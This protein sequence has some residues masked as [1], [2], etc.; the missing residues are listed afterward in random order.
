[1]AFLSKW[2]G[3]NNV[4]D[5]Q[6]THPVKYSYDT[7]VAL[8]AVHPSRKFPTTINQNTQVDNRLVFGVL[9]AIVFGISIWLL[10]FHPESPTNWMVYPL[11]A[12][13]VC[14]GLVQIALHS[15][16]KRLS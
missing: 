7:N 8:S 15:R 16:G 3:K 5:G 13:A 10:A 14:S 4:L 6:L 11:L 2:I 1:M 9:Y 12:A